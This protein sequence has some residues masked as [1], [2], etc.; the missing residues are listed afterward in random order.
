MDMNVRVKFNFHR[1]YSRRVLFFVSLLF[2]IALACS[3]FTSTFTGMSSFVLGV[4]DKIVNNETELK[5]ALNSATGPTI[6]KLNNDI[7]ITETLIIPANKD[8]TLTSSLF[9]FY[10]LIGA[11]GVDTLTVEGSGVLILDGIIVTHKSNSGR[12]VYVS[13]DGTLIMYGG[14]ISDNIVVTQLASNG[15]IYGGN[16]GGVYNAGIF[17]MHGGKISNNTAYPAFSTH[18]TS[19]GGGVYNIGTF[20][21]S[22]GEISNN[23][24]ATFGGGVCNRGTFNWHGG[25][26]SGNTAVNGKNVYPDDGNSGGSSNGNGGGSSNGNNGSFGGNNSGGPSDDGGLSGGESSMGNGGTFTGAGFGAWDI[27]V[28]CVGVVVVVVGVVVVVMLFYLQKRVGRVEE[29]L[30][31]Y[32]DG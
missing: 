18:D 17:E 3:G 8:I 32:V 7:T 14:E 26:I 20:S 21:M 27:V 25:M 31:I 30:N 16:G 15:Q 1:F 22:G 2:V 23:T 5:N 12:G 6:I 28:I 11:S 29:K 4:P 24:A 10:K 19:F 9:K 13:S